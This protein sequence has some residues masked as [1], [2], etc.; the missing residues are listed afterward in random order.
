ML[1]LHAPVRSTFARLL[2]ALL[3]VALPI[4]LLTGCVSEEKKRMGA[5]A[6]DYVRTFREG[7]TPELGLDGTVERHV[8][9]LTADGR[10]RTSHPRP[11][12][13]QFDVPMDS[14]T[15]TVNGINLV[16][17]PSDIEEGDITPYTISG[18]TL[19][20]RTNNRMRMGEMVTGYSMQIGEKAYLLRAR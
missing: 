5:L 11:S 2:R 18:D 7:V 6:G 16:L 3:A 19:F 4:L 12:L 15:Y 14:G 9:T 17:R 20:A 13:Q 1:P 8:L 10:Y